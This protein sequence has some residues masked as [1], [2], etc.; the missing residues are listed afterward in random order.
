MSSFLAPIRGR[1]VLTNFNQTAEKKAKGEWP[2]FAELCTNTTLCRDEVLYI[3]VDEMVNATLKMGVYSPSIQ[4][5]RFVLT[6]LLWFV[7]IY[8]LVCLL[9]VC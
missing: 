2:P 9:F 1:A 8:F 6:V 7:L 3:Y 4:S 5:D